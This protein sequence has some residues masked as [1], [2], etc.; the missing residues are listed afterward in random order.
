MILRLV[1]WQTEHPLGVEEGSEGILVVGVPACE[2]AGG[3]AWNG[4]LAFQEGGDFLSLPGI[5][6][7][8]LALGSGT[9]GVE[10]RMT[11]VG[12]F[13]AELVDFAREQIAVSLID[14][15]EGI[16]CDN[17]SFKVG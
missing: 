8:R 4:V 11:D 13:G 12:Q 17:P 6:I 10:M 9:P 15:N 1:H 14:G 2:L 7:A 16:G 5:G 3:V